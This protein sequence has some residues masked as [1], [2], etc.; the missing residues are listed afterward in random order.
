MEKKHCEGCRDD[1]YNGNNV[2]GIKECWGLKKAKIAKRFVVGTWMQPTFI[3][4]FKEVELPL[5]Y[6]FENKACRKI[7]NKLPTTARLPILLPKK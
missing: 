6:H 1:F 4:A 5:C 7:Y 2:L 3:G